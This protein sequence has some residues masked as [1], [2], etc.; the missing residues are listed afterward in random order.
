MQD[1]LELAEKNGITL[2]AKGSCQ[3]CGANTQR[4]IHECLEIFALDLE[5]MELHRKENQ[6]Y[7]F[8]LVDAHVLQHPEIHGRWSNHLHLARLHL[9]FNY[10]VNW[11]YHLTTQLSNCINKYKVGRQDEF[12]SPPDIHKRG[13]ITSTDIVK[14][15]S[16]K[17]DLM[18]LLKN[19]ANEVY[20]A[21]E[22]SHKTVDG[23]ATQF[24]NSGL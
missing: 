23:I 16:E 12:L 7:R 2:I 20:D 19:W 13:K 11:Y 18:P 1:Y 6:V 21:W 10:K 14:A 15:Y 9:I 5:N 8:Y 22:D 17:S 3:F 4:G 24:L